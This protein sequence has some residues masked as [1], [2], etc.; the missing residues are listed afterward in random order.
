MPA[1]PFPP[2]RLPRGPLPP[3]AGSSA[4]RPRPGAAGGLG[5]LLRAARLR[6]WG[7]SRRAVRTRRSSRRKGLT[8]GETRRLVSHRYQLQ[9]QTLHV[10]FKGALT[11]QKAFS[12]FILESKKLFFF[13]LPNS[14][15][16]YANY[17][18]PVGLPLTQP[19]L[20]LTF[21]SRTP[22]C[23]FIPSLTHSGRFTTRLFASN[24]NSLGRGKKKIRSWD[25]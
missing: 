10:F 1:A 14:E 17:F 12:L 21:S 19:L 18:K 5:A 23:I 3:A 16:I 15:G 20:S 8:C 22:E 13:F 2:G 25:I 9:K 4:T 24:F 11:V 6:R 7:R